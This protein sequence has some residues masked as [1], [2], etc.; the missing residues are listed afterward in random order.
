MKFLKILF[1]CF[2]CTPLDEK[3]DVGR[4]NQNK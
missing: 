3:I 1:F 4:K 2:V